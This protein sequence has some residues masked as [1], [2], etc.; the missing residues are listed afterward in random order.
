MSI[1]RIWF[2]L[3]DYI[4][5]LE[6]R[7]AEVAANFNWEIPD[8]VWAHFL[9]RLKEKGLQGDRRPNYVV[10]NIAVNGSYGPVEN[11]NLL[12]SM[13]HNLIKDA[14]D[15]G[16]PYD[17]AAAKDHLM[18]ISFEGVRDMAQAADDGA[19]LFFYEEPNSEYGLG[20]CYRLLPADQT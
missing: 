20:V 12:A 14:A 11:Y 7:K 1:R 16:I 17:E 3:E 2:D 18:D 10:D 6:T 8:G 19:A 15:E 9:Q 13:V 5:M 4:D